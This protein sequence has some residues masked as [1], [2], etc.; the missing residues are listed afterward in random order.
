MLLTEILSRW[1][2]ADSIFHSGTISRIEQVS[3]A[4][5]S[6]SADTDP[7]QKGKVPCHCQATVHGAQNRR[8]QL[9]RS[10]H[11]RNRAEDSR[12]LPGELKNS[13]PLL[14]WTASPCDLGRQS[15]VTDQKV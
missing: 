6:H 7:T 2:P 8:D 11:L 13:G 14:R 12:F 15:A 5:Q 4:N 9:F 1:P 10:V 3:A